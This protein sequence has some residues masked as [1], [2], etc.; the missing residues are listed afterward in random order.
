MSMNTKEFLVDISMFIAFLV[1]ALIVFI[2][3]SWSIA[4]LVLFILS[5]MGVL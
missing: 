2:A 1:I 3:L 4:Q 5:L